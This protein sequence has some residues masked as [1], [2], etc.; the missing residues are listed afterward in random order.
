MKRPLAACWSRRKRVSTSFPKGIR[1]IAQ[2]GSAAVLGTA[3]RWFESSCP[4]Q[5][6][7]ESV[8]FFP[9][10]SN[11]ILTH[12]LRRLRYFARTLCRDA[13]PPLL[14]FDQSASDTHAQHI[15]PSLVEIE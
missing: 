1:G 5:N 13:A 9:C 10:D 12:F 11:A 14:L 4:D 7:V 15:H 6:T 3:G 2:P 8:S